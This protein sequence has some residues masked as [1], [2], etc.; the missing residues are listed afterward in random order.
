[1]IFLTEFGVPEARAEATDIATQLAIAAGIDALRDAGIP[2]V[3][4]YKTTSRD[5]LLPNRW[6]L[7][8]ALQDETGVIFCSAFPG[9][10]RMSQETESYYRFEALKNQH[11]ELNGILN[12][13]N[14]SD[15]LVRQTLLKRLE[16]LQKQIDDIDYHFDRRFIFR[17]LTMGHSQFAEH[18]GARGPNT[19]VNAACATTTHAV[20]IAED[21]VRSGRCRRVIIVAG[22]DVTSGSLSNW[23]STGLLASGAA[24]TEENIRLAALPFD[25]RRNGMIM[26]MGAAALVVESQDAVAERGMQA[27]CELLS[28]V[29]ANSAFH[30]TRLDIKH[31]SEVM[32]RVVSQAEQRFGINRSEIA[33]Q[34]VFVSHETYTPARGGSAAA[35]IHAL[36]NTFGNQA[37]QVVIA[38]TK[39]FTG[40]TMGVGVE[41]IVAAKAL[42]FGIVPPIANYDDEF[43]PDP[44]LGDLNLSHGGSYPVNISL[45]LGAGF[46]SQIAMTILRKI[47]T[48][49]DRTD[50]PRY[51]QWLSAVSGY[52]HPEMEIVQHNLRIKH[53]GPR[54]S[55]LPPQTGSMDRD[56]PHGQTRNQSQP[57]CL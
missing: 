50:Q 38:N 48:T 46:G 24:T 13:T 57:P 29:T 23:I 28:S 2:L 6:M 55:N 20:S 33:A 34:T 41:D 56:Q 19:A 18:I 53:N 14:G 54:N 32:E 5:T 39:G 1:M 7:P 47:T 37:N 4:N 40:H 22:D 15:S 17:I 49:A 36:R 52:S 35:E 26:G 51:Q 44:E 25:R 8:E 11:A 30:G 43:E 9:L 45:R 16:E 12:L 21:W 3:M 31:V 27:F 10:D 42:Q